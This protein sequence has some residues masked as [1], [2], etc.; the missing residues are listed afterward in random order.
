MG[1]ENRS[2]PGSAC[3]ELGLGLGLGLGLEQF[4]E[5]GLGLDFAVSVSVLQSIFKQLLSAWVCVCV[6]VRE[7]RDDAIFDLVPLDEARMVR[8]GLRVTVTITVRIRD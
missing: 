6:C 8:V 4:F 5:L 1:P 3:L 7:K 2:S